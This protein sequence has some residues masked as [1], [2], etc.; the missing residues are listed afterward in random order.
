MSHDLVAIQVGTLDCRDVCRSRHILNDCV[1]KLLNT[2]VSVCGTAAYR[3]CC[4]LAGSFSQGCFQL[5][6]GRLFALQVFHHQ[7]VVQL[8]DLLDHA[9]YGTALRLPSCLPG[10]LGN[11]DVLTLL[12]IVDVSFHLEQVDDSLETHP[13]YR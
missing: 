5:L 2:L 9:L 10:Y 11:G 12:I 7:I 1:Q 6:C 4:T 8:A 13:P 3:N